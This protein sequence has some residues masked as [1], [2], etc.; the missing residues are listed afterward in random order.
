M[1]TIMKQ[2]SQFFMLNLLSASFILFTALTVN[3]QVSE[4]K[5]DDGGFGKFS[6]FDKKIYIS[7][8][9]VNYQVLYEAKKSKAGGQFGVGG[10][11]KGSSEAKG[12]LGLKDMSTEMLQK[13]TDELYANYV[14][15]LKNNGF[16]VITAENAPDIEAF[17]GFE[18]S[19]GGTP[20][21]LYPGTITCNPTGFSFFYEKGV[22]AKIGK[23]I[24]QTPSISRDLGDVIISKVCLNVEFAKSGQQFI[25]YGSSVKMETNL[26]VVQS[27]TASEIAEEKLLR[28][29]ENDVKTIASYVNFGVGKKMASVEAGYYG[30]IKKDV[31]IKGVIEDEKV[32]A[33]ADGKAASS[34]QMVGS[35]YAI[36]FY[37]EDVDKDLKEVE[38]DLPK[39]EEYVAEALDGVLMGHTKIFLSKY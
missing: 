7:E 14:K 17:K 10:H 33:F 15:E 21:V 16:D 25:K 29:K 18:Q 2:L 26:A 20:Y 23:I 5:L 1:N 31:A 36:L 30:T 28:T 35:N 24:D 3:A 38:V 8:F 6:R 12:A 37:E 19:T 32:N 4:I 13:M 11:Y 39:Y 27:L 22:K 34:Y 9:T